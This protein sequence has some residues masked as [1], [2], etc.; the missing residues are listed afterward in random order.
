MLK[1]AKKGQATQQ[2][3]GAQNFIGDNRAENGTKLAIR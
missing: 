1:L 2:Y 3:A